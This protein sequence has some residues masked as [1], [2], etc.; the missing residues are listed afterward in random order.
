MQAVQRK[1][2][3]DYKYVL[4]NGGFLPL[5]LYTYFGSSLQNVLTQEWFQICFGVDQFE[6]EIET[7]LWKVLIINPPLLGLIILN[8]PPSR[9]KVFQL[10]LFKSLLAQSFPQT[11][12]DCDAVK[13]ILSSTW[14]YFWLMLMLST[15]C[16][17]P[18]LL[19]QMTFFS[20]STEQYIHSVMHLFGSMANY[21]VLNIINGSV[22]DFGISSALALEIP[23]SCTRPSIS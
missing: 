5:T 21:D 4:K 16:S 10:P 20:Q 9:G 14:F 12:Y 22:Q 15:T 11:L 23:Q 7:I 18:N 3:L 19:Q 13:N 2:I 17:A 8:P 6:L 1:L